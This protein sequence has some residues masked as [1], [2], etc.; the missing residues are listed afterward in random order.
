M[1][2]V[3]TTLRRPP[4]R[5][6]RASRVSVLAGSGRAGEVRAILA[7]VLREEG[8]DRAAAAHAA[9]TQATAASNK[10]KQSRK[11]VTSGPAPGQQGALF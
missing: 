3:L 2:R 6:M 11:R 1:W 5:R 9:E 8:L 4:E 10:P 7:A